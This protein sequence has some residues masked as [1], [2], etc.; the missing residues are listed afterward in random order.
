MHTVGK[1]SAIDLQAAVASSNTSYEIYVIL[2]D[3]LYIIEMIYIYILKN[4]IHDI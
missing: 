4:M 3:L 2:Y 1:V